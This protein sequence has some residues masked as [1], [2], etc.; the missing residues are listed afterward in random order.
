M[1]RPK[2]SHQA[3]LCLAIPLLSIFLHWKV[4]P[5]DLM[6]IHVWRQTQTQSNI[7]NFYEEDFNIFN[8][9]RNERG[10]GDGIFRMEFPIMQWGFAGLHRIFGESIV[11]SRIASFVLGLCTVLGMYFLLWHC[12]RRR[13]LAMLGA[14]CFNFSPAFYYYTVN[15][16]PDNFALCCGVWGLSFFFAWQRKPNW[17]AAA[18]VAIFLSL[19]TLAKLPFILYAVLPFSYLLRNV[20][21]WKMILAMLSLQIFPLLWYLQVIPQWKGNGIV[22]GLL[23]A[24][25]DWWQLLDYFQHNVISTLPELLINYAA[26][27]FFLAGIYYT[28]RNKIYQRKR[29]P[30][31]LLTLLA[32]LAFFLFELNMIAKIHD[33]Y[34][35]PFFPFIFMLVSYGA[36]Q[37]WQTQQQK[38]RAFILLACLLVPLTCTLRMTSRWNPAQPGFNRDLLTHKTALRAAVPKDAL[39]VVGN[40]DSHYIFLYYIDKKGWGFT[41]DALTATMLDEMIAQGAGYLYT[42]SRV[43]DQDPEIKKRLAKLVLSK[44]TIQIY[45]LQKLK[46]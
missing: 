21:H 30:E 11:V 8:P 32:L 31:L 45:R 26:T 39:C 43:V 6:S 42:D 4:F 16:L 17:G 24:E 25:Q 3:I 41:G 40:D 37:L 29:F 10:S 33:Y 14:W 23:S 9:R 2:I 22:Q 5:L 15:P 12:F 36:W 34:L 38:W 19:S 28:F 13:Y 7:V 18:L 27:P 46:S 1:G 35:F 20:R 44:G